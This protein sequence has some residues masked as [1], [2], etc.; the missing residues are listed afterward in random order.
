MSAPIVSADEAQELLKGTTPGPWDAWEERF[1]VYADV[2]ENDPGSLVGNPVCSVDTWRDGQHDPDPDETDC[3]CKCDGCEVCYPTCAAD[4][5]LICAAP[6][7]AAT[8]VALHARVAELEAEAAQW[9][10]TPTEA[11]KAAH[12]AR[13]G[14][15]TTEGR[16]VPRDKNYARVAWPE[17]SRG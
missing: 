7:L 6:R 14:K 5:R 10:R 16:W 12:D 11:E 9:T 13:G 17:V 8:V 1:E 4:V 3:G 15:W 2:T